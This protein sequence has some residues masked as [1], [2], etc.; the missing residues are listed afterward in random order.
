MRR[1]I[2]GLGMPAAA[3]ASPAPLKETYGGRPS[4]T[5]RRTTPE[6]LKTELTDRMMANRYELVS[7]SNRLLTFEAPIESTVMALLFASQYD[8]TPKWRIGLTLVPVGDGVRVVAN[9]KALTN[10]GSAFEKATD[11]PGCTGDV[12]DMLNRLSSAELAAK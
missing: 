4:A 1:V 5:V 3:C 2:I 8:V 9:C 10:P 7:E 11:Y 12:R 6:A